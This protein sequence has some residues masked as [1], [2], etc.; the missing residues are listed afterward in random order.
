MFVVPHDINEDGRV[1]LVAGAKGP[2]AQVGWLEAPPAPRRLADWRWHPLRDAGWI[3]SLVLADM[4]GDG[5]EDIAVSDRK[6]EERG[7]FWLENPGPASL[8]RP[9]REHAVGAQGGEVMF[10][11]VAP[12]DRDTTERI[13]VSTKPREIVLLE[14]RGATWTETAIPTPDTAGTAKAVTTGDVDGDGVLDLVFSC[15]GAEGLSGVM[16]LSAREAGG[17]ES[18]TA[19]GISGRAGTKF[20]LVELIDLDHDGDLDVLTC[21]EREGLG[22]VWYE[23][24]Y[25]PAA[26][27]PAPSPR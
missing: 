18:W 26:V 25:G 1:D 24:P 9:W 3:M 8:D 19:R 7:V 6:G 4:N 21:E 20:D 12:A 23:N 11:T 14:R 13:L 22:V 2:G 5:D 27:S 16:W 15:E 17:T 10:L